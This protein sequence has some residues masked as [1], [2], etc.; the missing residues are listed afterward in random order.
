MSNSIMLHKH[1]LQS[2]IGEL[3]KGHGEVFDDGTIQI[4]LSVNICAPIKAQ[5]KFR[6]NKHQYVKSLYR[7][8]FSQAFIR[9]ILHPYTSKM[10]ID[11]YDFL[12]MRLKNEEQNNDNNI[13]Y[14]FNKIRENV[15]FVFSFNIIEEYGL[16]HNRIKNDYHNTF[17]MNIL[18]ALD[19]LFMEMQKQS[20]NMIMFVSPDVS[21]I[22]SERKITML[23]LEA[24]LNTSL[25]QNIKRQKLINMS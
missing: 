12:G 3:I 23:N 22:R 21:R 17:I 4:V 14:E 24:D 20:Q 8:I 1:P 13:I 11:G 18:K 9:D 16:M 5:K 6:N 2:Y 19:Y 25:H 7:T 10:R 15:G